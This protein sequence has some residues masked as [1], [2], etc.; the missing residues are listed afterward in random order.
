MGQLVVISPGGSGSGGSGTPSDSNPTDVGATTAAGTAT[1]YSRGDHSHKLGFGSDARGDLAVR[2]ASA[3]GRLAIGASGRFLG[4]DGTDPS[5]VD[6]AATLV[7]LANAQTIN[8][9]KRFDEGL[10]VAT[11]K[12]VT[13]IAELN[14][15]AASAQPINF[16]PGNALGGRWFPSGGLYIGDTPIDPGQGNILIHNDHFIQGRSGST[17][18]ALISIQ[19]GRAVLGDAAIETRLTGTFVSLRTAYAKKA[20]LISD[21]NVSIAFSDY[22]VFYSSITAARVAT[23]LAPNSDF[24]TSTQPQYYL[25]GDQS[26]SCSGTNTITV[27]VSGGSAIVGNAS[28]IVSGN[29]VLGSPYASVMLKS[30]G[31]NYQ[32]VQIYR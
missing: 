1:E 8:G 10:T 28:D 29:V 7:T 15:A 32:I 19:S 12:S 17:N 3:Y 13:G 2:G 30:N 6:P 24:G 18:Y 22:A 23:M 14:L 31:T 27:T 25:I 21:A 26:G 20:R 16:S 9:L 5:W 11:A 4:S